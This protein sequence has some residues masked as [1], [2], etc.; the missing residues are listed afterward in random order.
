M[1]TM[2]RSDP[3]PRSEPTHP[4]IRNDWVIACQTVL[5]DKLTGKL[6]LVQVLDHLQ[7]PRF[8]ADLP[9]FYVVGLWQHGQDVVAQARLR[10]ELEEHGELGAS[11]LSE[12]QVEFPGRTAHRTIC[13]VHA[14]TVQR[15]G[16]YRLIA[17]LQ[18]PDGEWLDGGAH[19]LAITAMPQAHLQ[20]QA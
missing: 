7:V 1:A 2:N 14:L 10:I 19:T 17:R 15:P 5:V 8:P 4:A 18:G 6:S 9:P 3:S 20:A 11:V 16:A 12:E 13:V